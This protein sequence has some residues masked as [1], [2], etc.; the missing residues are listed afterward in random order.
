MVRVN[1]STSDIDRFASSFPI[2]R[3]GRP[4][5]VAA[6]VAYLCSNEAAYLTGVAVDINGGD[7]MV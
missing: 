1:T 7:L 2:P 4:E 3:L 6:L 5:E